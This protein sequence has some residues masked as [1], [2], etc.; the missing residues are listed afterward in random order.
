MRAIDYFD[1]Q[2]EVQP[3]RIAIIEGD[4]R[5][6]YGDVRAASQRIARAMWA[7]AAS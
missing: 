1:K 2:A 4:V 5:Y 3:E 7:S 6:S